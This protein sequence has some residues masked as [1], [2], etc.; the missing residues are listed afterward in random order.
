MGNQII[1][2]PDGL[3]AV[4]STF[5]DTFVLMDATPDEIVYWFGE[6]AAEAER[7][8][9]QTVLDHVLADNPRA[10]YF[11]F[12]HTWEEACQ[13]NQEHGGDLTYTDGKDIT[14]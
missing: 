9:T 12:A 2:Q 14:R 11:Q 7:R 10:A 5:T 4:F 1:K 13:T 8:R 3:L 6:R